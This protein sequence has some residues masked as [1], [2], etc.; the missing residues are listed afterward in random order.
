MKRLFFI[1]VVML[2]MLAAAGC[3][4]K[5]EAQKNSDSEQSGETP[6]VQ[7][8]D[9]GNE[10]FSRLLSDWILG[11]D[12]GISDVQVESEAKRLIISISQERQ[13]ALQDFDYED[14]AAAISDMLAHSGINAQNYMLVWPDGTMMELGGGS[15]GTAN[16]SEAVE[17]TR[18][19]DNMSVG[20]TN[21]DAVNLIFIHHSV[22][23]NWLY[24]GLNEMLN[25]NGY[26]V[27]DTYYGWD[28]M[29][30]STDTVDWPCWFNEAYMPKV[31]AKLSTE[32][33]SNTIE[34]APGENEIVMFKSCFP[35]SEVGGSISDEQ[36]IYNSLLEYFG[37]HSD[38][39]FILVT[40]PPMQ[41][42]SKAK[43]TRELANWLVSKDGWLD[44]FSTGNVFVFD[45]YNVLTAP[46]N[47]HYFD[48]TKEV[49][50]I[51][52]GSNELYYDSGGDDHPNAD[53][54]R[55]AAEEFVP[56]LNYWYRQFKDR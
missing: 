37:A 42:I 49:H 1:I 22:G 55:K 27:A 13:D 39:M 5:D 14:I 8:N 41:H 7:A 18:G 3:Q 40:P 9:V 47:H 20:G 48:G 21:E 53:G 23:E 25:D 10:E 29:G 28:D 46:D 56:L 35:N 2:L 31:Y 15:V 50:E 26:H 11:T 16:V 6:V 52:D 32:T 33:A 34:A 36:S 12:Y 44:G 4:E 54:N 51:G 43:K 24:D 17:Q 45:L 19:N 30:D 38:K